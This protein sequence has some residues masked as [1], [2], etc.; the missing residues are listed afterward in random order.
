MIGRTQ[1]LSKADVTVRADVALTFLEAA[2][3]FGTGTKAELSVAGS[4][5]A[6]AGIAAADATCGKILGYCS[7]R[8]DHKQ[9]LDL[10]DRATSP[11]HGPRRNRRG[12]VSVP[13][14][15]SRTPAAS[16]AAMKFLSLAS[17]SGFFL[18]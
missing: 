4:N 18:I 9:A 13:R 14:A 12:G 3:V 6:Q 7:T 17:A 10:L 5:A 11:D 15:S 8:Q 16:S 2:L 1:P